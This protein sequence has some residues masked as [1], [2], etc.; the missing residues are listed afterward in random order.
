MEELPAANMKLYFLGTGSQKPSKTRNVTSIALILESGHYILF[1]CGE[2]T[3]HQI[4]RSPLSLSN[5]DAIFITHLHGDHV[6]GLPGLLCSL[7]E[8]LNGKEFTIYG[9]H[10]L[11]DFISSVLFNRVH[12]IL[13]Y[14]LNIVEYTST[15]DSE[16]EKP[17]IIKGHSRNEGNYIIRNFPVL[18]TYGVQGHTYGFIIKQLDQSI[19]FKQPSE[20]GLFDL[21]QR[22]KDFVV[23]WIKETTGKEKQNIRSILGLLQKTDSELIINDSELGEVNI[24]TDY[25][26]VDPPKRGKCVCLIIDSSDSRRAIEAL[27]GLECDILVHEST[28]A[29][30]SLDNEK[31][32]EEI[33]FETIKHGH[34]TPQLAGQLANVINAKQLVLTHFSARYSGDESDNNLAI[35]EEIRQSAIE[36]FGKPMVITARD[37]ME[38]RLYSDESLTQAETI[39]LM[40]SQIDKVF[41]GGARIIPLATYNVSYNL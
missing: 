7:N 4:L 28:N 16:L 20:S 24:R 5:L 10:G 9:P 22:N 15:M 27:N 36:I 38:I 34:S 3:Q 32:Y 21:L 29:K 31:S 26:Y 12:C 33:E 41:A 17:I 19:K 18:H 6:Y 1:D 37:F 8:I 35:M 23:E 40:V 13:Q 14:T 2:G 30:T 11:K 25:R 39:R